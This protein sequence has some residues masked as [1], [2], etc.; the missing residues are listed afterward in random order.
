MQPTQD[1]FNL[2][3]ECRCVAARS[4]DRKKDTKI[5]ERELRYDRVREKSEM[6]QA[7]PDVPTAPSWRRE[8][9]FFPG[10]GTVDPHPSRGQ[11]DPVKAL[12]EGGTTGGRLEPGDWK[13]VSNEFHHNWPRDLL[14]KMH[15]LDRHFGI[16]ATLPNYLKGETVEGYA[17]AYKKA[18]EELSFLH[19]LP[20]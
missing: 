12:R 8:E 16:P 11:R 4:G 1:F 6:G 5:K 10:V 19:N 2:A 17:A 14:P 18:T 7:I 9:D 13:R 15:P 3:T 20:Q